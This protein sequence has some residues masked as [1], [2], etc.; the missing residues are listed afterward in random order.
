MMHSTVTLLSPQRRL[1]VSSEDPLTRCLC[2]VKSRPK[3]NG[4]IFCVSRPGVGLCRCCSSEVSTLLSA[5]ETTCLRL[6]NLSHWSEA[7]QP[8]L[9]LKVCKVAV[10]LWCWFGNVWG[11]YWGGNIEE[12]Q[13]QSKRLFRPVW[14]I[15]SEKK[16]KKKKK[17]KTSTDRMDYTPPDL[18]V[19]HQ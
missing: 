12:T 15:H 3:R 5:D 7:Q 18:H 1:C 4:S 8:H 2:A 14:V 16:K 6:R 10:C 17:K 19:V 11:R 9:R 13:N